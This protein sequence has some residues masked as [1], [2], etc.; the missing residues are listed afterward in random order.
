MTVGNMPDEHSSCSI[1]AY[2]LLPAEDSEPHKNHLK[3]KRSKKHADEQHIATWPRER[4]SSRYQRPI[5]MDEPQPQLLGATEHYHQQPTRRRH[6]F[7]REQAVETSFDPLPHEEAVMFVYQDPATANDVSPP[8]HPLYQPRSGHLWHRHSVDMTNHVVP[9]V[10]RTNTL[11]LLPQ[12]VDYRHDPAYHP[13]MAVRSS[14][15]Q[16]MISFPHQ[17]SESHISITGHRGT[18]RLLPESASFTEINRLVNLNIDAEILRNE[19][20]ALTVLGTAT[21]DISAYQ[22]VLSLQELIDQVNHEAS[23]PRG[24]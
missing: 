19:L 17:D 24:F 8:Y 9:D 3:K 16:T 18:A 7:S 14:E 1:C 5:P 11:P 22:R 23:L 15:T 2:H 12:A 20:T 10:Y 4:P 6:Q 21:G 13:R